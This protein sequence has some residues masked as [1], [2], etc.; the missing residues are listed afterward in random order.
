MPVH[1]H[2]QNPHSH[3]YTAYFGGIKDTGGSP[4]GSTGVAAT[5]AGATATNQNAGS[6]NSHENKPPYASVYKIIIFRF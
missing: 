4:P 5:T 6:G 1:T 2:I 3:G